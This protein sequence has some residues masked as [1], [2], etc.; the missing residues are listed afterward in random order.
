MIHKYV[1][2]VT[3]HRR[4]FPPPTAV[5]PFNY[6]LLRN[7][8]CPAQLKESIVSR[9]RLS[10]MPD[11][12]SLRLYVDINITTKPLRIEIEFPD[13]RLAHRYRESIRKT[14]VLPREDQ[15]PKVVVFELPGSA[16]S[17]ES[18]RSLQAFIVH[19]KEKRDADEWADHVCLHVKDHERQVMI[20]QYWSEDEEA[21]LKKHLPRYMPP[22][23][24]PPANRA[25][26]PPGEAR[27]SRK[28]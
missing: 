8:N 22:P 17:L 5:T 28:S 25:G 10:S 23:P 26:T 19:F 11:T 7:A 24:P 18:S 9:Y 4:H 16:R 2:R 13:E 20:K 27:R 15:E 6:L 3:F 1:G 21:T 14:K 12:H